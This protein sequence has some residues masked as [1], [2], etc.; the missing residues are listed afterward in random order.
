MN[1]F[2][3]IC[4][5]FNVLALECIIML[6]WGF[7]YVWLNIC[8]CLYVCLYTL[9]KESISEWTWACMSV[10]YVCEWI[11]GYIYISKFMCVSLWDWTCEHVDISV[12]MS[13]S[14]FVSIQWVNGVHLISMFMCECI[15]IVIV[16]A[17]VSMSRFM[18][19]WTHKHT[20]FMIRLFFGSWSVSLYM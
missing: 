9:M 20:P 15:Y 17:F 13:V 7:T 10:F 12:S 1:D 4:V 19:K 8:L 11:C 14:K 18:Y 16:E 2:V 3:N 5:W 6:K